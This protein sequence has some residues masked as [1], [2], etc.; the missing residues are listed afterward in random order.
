[1]K[2]ETKKSL[3]NNSV[4]LFYAIL[5]IALVIFS[6][7]LNIWS[8]SGSAEFVI[9]LIAFLIVG[10][11]FTQAL[12]NEPKKTRKKISMIIT[13]VLVVLAVLALIAFVLYQVGI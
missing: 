8:G 2:I 12:Q 6:D 4:I 10:Q 5:M 13:I 11:V 1:M 7:N 9:I 3:K